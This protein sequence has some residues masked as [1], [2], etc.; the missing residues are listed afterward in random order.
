M[1]GYRSTSGRLQ[2]PHLP[3]CQ[4][5]ANSFHLFGPITTHLAG[6]QSA[7][8]TWR[9]LKKPVFTIHP[10]LLLMFWMNGGAPLLCL[11]RFMTCKGIT[12]CSL[13]CNNFFFFTL[14]LRRSIVF[15]HTFRKKSAVDIITSDNSYH[16]PW[17]QNFS[18]K[19]TKFTHPIVLSWDQ[20]IIKRSN[21]QNVQL[22]PVK[23]KVT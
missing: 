14:E 3:H 2:T 10:Y 21:T 16:P 23:G 7:T 15:F 13:M 8:M 11:Y 5:H 9:K 17:R 18:N 4:T 22:L 20:L 12:L 19:I 1:T 6:K